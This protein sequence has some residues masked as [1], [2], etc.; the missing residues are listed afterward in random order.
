[1]FLRNHWYVAAWSEDIGREPISRVM[2]GELVMLY[3]TEDGWPVALEDRCPHRNLP[4]SEGNL[5]GDVVQ[6]LYHG[7]EFGADG[8]CVHVPGQDNVPDWA[9]VKRYP[10]AER[11]R[12]VFV[13]MGDP[14][15][16]DE[17]AVPDYSTR[18][19]DPEWITISGY[20]VVRCGYRLILDNLLDLSHLAYVHAR[21]TGNAALAEDAVLTTEAEGDRVR[22]TRWMEDIEPAP[23]FRRFGGFT[24]NI[25]RWQVSQFLPPSYININNGADDAGSGARGP[26][27]LT[28]R[29]KW[30]FVVYH[31]MTPE[32]ATTTHQFWAVS[33][34]E[35]MVPDAERET[36]HA[37]MDTVIP[38]DTVV[39]EAQQ[40][41]IDRDP[42]AHDQDANPKGALAIDQALLEM[43]RVIRRLHRAEQGVAPEPNTGRTLP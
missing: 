12:W 13:W 21:T 17:A 33:I 41:A 2:L 9:R 15:A 38:E 19:V 10:V 3:R 7:L 25:D 29:G 4:L 35:R 20:Q 27:Q 31:A 26:E 28:S 24:G 37:Q 39:Y 23:A 36:F 5:V 14:E 18:L 42:D 16:A 22:I 8:V 1:M 11:N 34:P 6:C 30:G 43:R 32:S 40:A